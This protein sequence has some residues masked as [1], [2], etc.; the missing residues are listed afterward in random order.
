MTF[1]TGTSRGTADDLT[2]QIGGTDPAR[3][4]AGPASTGTAFNTGSL[5]FSTGLLGVAQAVSAVTL[6]T[7]DVA[8]V[9]FGF[10][11]DTVTNVNDSGAGS[12]RQVMANANAL[13][14]DGSLAQ[15]GR[16]A[17]VEH[18][19]FMIANGTAAAGLRA[20]INLFTSSPGNQAVA[21]LAPLTPLP[22]ITSALTLDAQTQPGWTSVPVVDI[23]GANAGTGSTAHGLTVSAASTAPC[24]ACCCGALP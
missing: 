12:L 17:G 1:R 19:V 16:A 14:G 23:D 21:A 9:D 15:A 6:S 5:E 11:F 2:D 20:S 3:A 10:N 13:G 24:A 4:D 7:G 18:V 8:G 22:A